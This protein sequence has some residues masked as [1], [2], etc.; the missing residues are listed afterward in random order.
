MQTL[1]S[2]RLVETHSQKLSDSRFSFLTPSLTFLS[3]AANIISNENNTSKKRKIS[4]L[5]NQADSL[6]E[7]PT[8]KQK[9]IDIVKTNQR[10]KVAEKDSANDNGPKEGQ[11]N[12]TNSENPKLNFQ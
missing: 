9:L 8:K 6:K 10:F 4:A 5:Q 12:L 3:E 11:S 1:Q 2:F 7:R